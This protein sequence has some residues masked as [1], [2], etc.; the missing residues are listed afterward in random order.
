MRTSEFR[1]MANVAV[2]VNEA[3]MAVNG[4]VAPPGMSVWRRGAM[5][6][7]V[8]MR[9]ALRGGDGIKAILEM[10]TLASAACADEII[11]TWEHVD[12]AVLCGGSA[13]AVSCAVLACR[14]T[15]DGHSLSA[16]PFDP[17]VLDQRPGQ[18]VH[19]VWGEP[20]WELCGAPLPGVMIELLRLCWQRFETP[21]CHEDAAG[22]YLRDLGHHVDL[23]A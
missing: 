10:S 2:K 19:P 3:V 1:A 17:N 9:P 22:V 7:V 16:F 11:V 6:G 21:G 4:C 12:L 15:P 18:P 14:A 20:T 5:V 8:T 23:C 13:P